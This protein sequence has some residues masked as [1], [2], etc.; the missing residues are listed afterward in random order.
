MGQVVKVRCNFYCPC[1]E[2]ALVITVVSLP[3]TS[4]LCG[5]F[6]VLCLPAHY[7]KYFNKILFVFSPSNK[8]KLT[9]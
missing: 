3:C 2:A 5:S 4:Y 9:P 8:I 7:K 6:I 1:K